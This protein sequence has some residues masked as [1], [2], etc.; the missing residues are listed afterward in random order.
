MPV[1]GRAKSGAA[2]RP[3]PIDAATRCASPGATRIWSDRTRPW[4]HATLHGRRALIATCSAKKR[5]KVGGR[6]CVTRIGVAT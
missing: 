1:V 6:C 5:L 3:P 2:I 4:S